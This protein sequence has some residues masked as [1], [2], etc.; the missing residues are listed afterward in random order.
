[1]D[2]WRTGHVPGGLHPADAGDLNVGVGAA[3]TDATGGQQH[4]HG[5]LG[6][7]RTYLVAVD[8]QLL[9]REEVGAAQLLFDGADRRMGCHDPLDDDRLVPVERCQRGEQA[10]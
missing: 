2:A 4:R 8:R 10:H 7:E 1:M 5:L 9:T 3:R 6:L